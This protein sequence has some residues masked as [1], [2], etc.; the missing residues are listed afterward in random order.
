MSAVLVFGIETIPDVPGF[1]RLHGLD[2][3]LSDAEAAEL[4]FQMRRAQTGKDS[5]PLHL[6][7]VAAISCVLRS[8]HGLRVWSLAE[9][10][11]REAE[12]IQGFFDGIEE[13]TPQ[14]VSWNGGAFDLPVL[15]YRGLVHGVRALRHGRLGDGDQL[16]CHAPHAALTDLLAIGQPGAAVPLGE[17][18]RLIGFP[19]LRARDDARIWEAWQRGE[20]AALRDGC[21]TAA[22][23]TYL[24]YQRLRLMR[25]ETTHAEYD[26]EIAFVRRALK[27]IDIPLWH[28]FLA[29]WA[30]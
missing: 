20:T 17:L 13:S 15:H 25:G 7:R 11:L 6:Q 2:P 1:R 24:V 5:L 23:N 9:P 27:G 22:M 19:G 28:E 16:A 10:E 12:I 18:A 21:E 30:D 26:G 3:A 14:L 8:E 4:A 29:A